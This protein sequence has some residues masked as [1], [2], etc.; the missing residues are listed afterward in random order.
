MSSLR[1]SASAAILLSA[2]GLILAAPQASAEIGTQVLIAGGGLSNGFGT[3]CTYSVIANSSSGAG[4]N[5][6]DN[7]VW[8]ARTDDSPTPKTHVASWTPT[9]VG[10]HTIL[11]TQN[12]DSKTIVLAVGTGINGGSSCLVL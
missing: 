5:F 6:F 4:M 12:D 8:F 3:G 1:N 2:A 11:V 10:T 7:G 9:T